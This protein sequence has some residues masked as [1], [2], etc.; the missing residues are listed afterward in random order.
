MTWR[1]LVGRTGLENRL[2]ALMQQWMGSIPP[3]S[4]MIKSVEGTMYCT[5]DPK[6]KV[7]YRDRVRYKASI[8][9]I[10][11][12]CFFVGSCSYNVGYNKAKE[13][14]GNETVTSLQN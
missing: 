10:L 9:W 2:V 5:P 14:M 12:W 7:V 4:V 11:F 6:P 13:E 8:F 1:L 3:A